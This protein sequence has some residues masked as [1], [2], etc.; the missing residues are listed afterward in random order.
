VAGGWRSA[1]HNLYFSPNTVIKSRRMTWA[2][3]VSCTA[4]MRNTKFQYESLNGRHHLGDKGEDDMIILQWILD[5]QGM[6]V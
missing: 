2:G 5:K 1:L 6:R 3:H 4:E